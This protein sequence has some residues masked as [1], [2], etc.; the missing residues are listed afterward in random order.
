ML[1][2]A[3]VEDD[4]LYAKQLQ[5]YLDQYAKDSGRK[6]DVRFFSDGEDIIDN[7]RAGFHIILMDIQMRFLDGLTTAKR[8]KGNHHFHH[9]HGL[10]CD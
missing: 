1:H 8:R 7:Y 2:L 4:P 5:E 3:V 9:Q 6:F 10:L